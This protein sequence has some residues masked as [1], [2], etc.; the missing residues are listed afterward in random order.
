MATQSRAPHLPCSSVRVSGWVS[1]D[2]AALGRASSAIAL[3][4]QINPPRNHTTPNKMLIEPTGPDYSPQ[5]IS[6]KPLAGAL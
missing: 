2:V 5:A 6:L 1:E 4:S 3:L